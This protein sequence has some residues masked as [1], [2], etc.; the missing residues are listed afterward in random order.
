[1]EALKKIA[2]SLKTECGRWTSTSQAL[3]KAQADEE[4]A[5]RRAQ[6]KVRKAE[7]RQV[8]RAQ[9]QEE[10]K[11]KQEEEKY[12]KKVAAEE[13]KAQAA[14]RIAAGETVEAVNGGRKKRKTPG[15]QE[16]TEADPVVIQSIS[17]FK[18]GLMRVCETIKDFVDIIGSQPEL[19]CVAR[20]HRG[21]FKKVLM[22]I[23]SVPPSEVNLIQKNLV[24]QCT[25]FTDA[26]TKL[27]DSPAPSASADRDRVFLSAEGPVDLLAMDSLLAANV[28]RAH[29][30]RTR[31]SPE[32]A[33]MDTAVL[34]RDHLVGAL[35]DL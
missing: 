4:A 27:F 31:G 21:M 5:Q 30:M 16:V 33:E 11:R 28:E 26:S 15:V 10:R 14:A 13:Q 3:L 12:A 35:L 6:E 23:D 9:E 22:E 1:M 8:K 19:P 32:S 20:L 2:E 34:D 17:D 29:M 24:Q 25:D 18:G 7:E